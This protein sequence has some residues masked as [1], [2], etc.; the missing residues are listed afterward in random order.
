MG[1]RARK[2]REREE[3]ENLMLVEGRRMLVEE[4][5][6]GLNMDRLAK[7]VDYSKGTIY[8][9]FTTKEDLMLAIVTDG[10][11]QRTKLFEKA[12]RL[13]GRPRERLA[14][15]GVADDLFVALYPEHFHVEHLVRVDSLWE[16]TSPERQQALEEAAFGC[17]RCCSVIIEEGIHTGDLSIDPKQ[18]AEM[19]MMLMTASLGMHLVANDPFL[20]RKFGIEDF[21]SV[22]RTNYDR[23]LD[24]WGWRPLSS[25]WDYPATYERIESELFAEEFAQLRGGGAAPS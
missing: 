25:E 24:G 6:L 16:K 10:K 5:Y 20:M 7:A 12:L 9:H 15:I 11:Q 8:Q 1:T 18:G 23:Y 4:G 21:G 17:H 2:Q 14:A 3:R 22:M 19:F 13:S